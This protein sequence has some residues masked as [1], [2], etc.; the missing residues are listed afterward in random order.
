MTSGDRRATWEAT[1]ANVA[2]YE[3]AARVNYGPPVKRM[4]LSRGSV[5]LLFAL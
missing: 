1:A 4:Q 5:I 3:A 2:F